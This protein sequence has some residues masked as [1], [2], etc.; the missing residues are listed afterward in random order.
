[1][2]DTAP[3]GSEPRTEDPREDYAA[4]EER[5]DDVTESVKKDRFGEGGQTDARGTGTQGDRPARETVDH[6]ADDDA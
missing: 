5:S 1:M 3:A 4:V 6:D 2:A